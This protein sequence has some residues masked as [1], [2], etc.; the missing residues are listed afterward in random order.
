MVLSCCPSGRRL[1]RHRGFIGLADPQRCAAFAARPRLDEVAHWLPN[2]SRLFRA[3][4]KGDLFFFK[5]RGASKRIAG[6]GFFERYERMPAYQVWDTF[7]TGTGEPDRDTLLHTI[8]SMRRGTNAARLPTNGDFEVGCI[9]ITA[10]VFFADGDHVEAPADWPSVGIQQGMGYD[11][12]HGEGLRILD[13]CLERADR[14]PYWNVEKVGKGPQRD[15]NPLPVRPRLG[16]GTFRLAV[17]DAYRNTCAVT[18]DRATPLLQAAHILPLRDGGE[19]RVANGL[20]LRCDVRT[21]YDL[22]YATVTP[23][24]EFLVSMSITAD[25]YHG[26]TYLPMSGRT[27]VVPFDPDSHP[28]R[29]ALEQHYASVYKH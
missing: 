16:Q 18:D 3:L 5:T 9:I 11:L 2:T 26:Y 6:F 23:D 20:L 21:L 29:D 14:H 28:D 7:G 8:L 12:T 15:A 25:Y 27:I 13:E 17:I 22:G 10:P 19:H 1:T 4:D 24:Y